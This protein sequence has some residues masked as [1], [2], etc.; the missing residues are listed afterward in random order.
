MRYLWQVPHRLDNRSL[1]ALIGTEPHTP[2]DVA[3]DN[4]LRAIGVLPANAINAPFA[5]DLATE[6]L[7][8]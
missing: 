8:V 7:K 2:F 3:V 1:L 5:P 6:P 4:A